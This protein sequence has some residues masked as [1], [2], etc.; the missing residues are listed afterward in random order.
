MSN[1]SAW[2]QMAPGIT[3]HDSA[4]RV[5]EMRMEQGLIEACGC[6]DHDRGDE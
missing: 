4:H 3:R 2:C 1:L 6:P 5:C